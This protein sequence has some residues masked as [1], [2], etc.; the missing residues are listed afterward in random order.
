MEKKS[1]IKIDRIHNLDGSGPTKAFCDLII[2]DT[3][4]V[5][6]FRIVEGKEGL[7]VSM[8]RE[9][10]RDGKWYDTFYPAAKEQRKALND[11]ILDKYSE[12]NK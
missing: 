9:Q 1:M 4:I 10:G 2:M 5:K 6:G 8:P 11:L 7:F 12:N 3:F